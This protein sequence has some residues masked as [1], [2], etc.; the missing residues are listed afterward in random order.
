[1]NKNRKKLS[2]D[3]VVTNLLALI[4]PL[5]SQRLEP[6]SPFTATQ[7]SVIGRRV[8]HKWKE[9]DGSERFYSGNNRNVIY[10]GEETVL[11]INLIDIER[12]DL[13]FV[14]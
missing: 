4:S 7:E 3:E 5:H 10:D 11:S 9:S 6:V 14:D 13:N 8:C 12:G 1:M 2:V